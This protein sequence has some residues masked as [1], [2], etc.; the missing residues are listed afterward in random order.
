MNTETEP[1][2]TTTVATSPVPRPTQSQIRRWALEHGVAIPP[3]GKISNATWAKWDEWF[4]AETAD[5]GAK[6]QK[7]VAR[8][9]KA[10]EAATARVQKH[11]ED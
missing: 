9:H 1:T 6:L 8:A 3:K 11:F 5:A 4:L 7:A 10:F 2:S